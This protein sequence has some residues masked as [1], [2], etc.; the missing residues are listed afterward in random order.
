MASNDR[1]IVI[2]GGGIIGCCTAY[3]LTRHP[4]FDPKHH[5]IT[6]LETSK[7]AGGASGKAG[8]LLAL[9]AYPKEIVPLSYRTHKELAEKH[10]G[11]KRWDYRPVH[12]G[13]IE[14]K[15][16]QLRSTDSVEGKDNDMKGGDGKALN[17]EKDPNERV[18]LQKRSAHA[19]SKLRAAGVPDDLD[20]IEP[21]CL[22]GYEEMSDPTNS[23]Q[24]HP[25]LF[26]TAMA[27]LA[28]EAGAD[29]R[30]GAQVKSITYNDKGDQV[31]GVTYVDKESGRQTGL[32][33]TD[34]VISA[35]PWTSTVYPSAPISAL[36]A[37]S[38]TIKP[39]RPVSAYTLFTSIKLPAGFG[40]TDEARRSEGKRSQIVTPEIYARQ[41]EI[42]ACGEGD[43]LV[44]LPQ[45]TDEVQVDETRCQDVVDYACSVSD[46]LRD[47]VV[48]ARQACY[49][50]E[51]NAKP[52]HP[53]IG[54][55]GV[56][57]LWMCAGH[58]CWGI[59][60]G[61]GSGKLMSEFIFDGK[62]KSAN[63]AAMDP[64]AVL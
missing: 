18:S 15:G 10:N 11:A 20:W 60:N 51:V 33:A 52:G 24:V 1:H 21:E 26:T 23:A 45:S 12:C 25:F 5:K 39:T 43:R 42:Y 19:M 57:G 32:Q 14:C 34:V 54:P 62:A 46:E 50:P 13:Q 4:S 41:T 3:F 35:G 29:I 44:P 6:L 49:L 48:T 63:V 31:T 16:R 47:G 22:Q 53:L 36:R 37:H 8:G 9:W 40:R 17:G 38:V 7:I 59:Q 64:R 27:E 55:T 30:V 56:K 28:K 58:T 61:P 2:I